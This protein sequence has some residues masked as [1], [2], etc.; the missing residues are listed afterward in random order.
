MRFSHGLL[1]G[2]GPVIIP[3]PEINVEITCPFSQ[4]KILEMQCD[5]LISTFQDPKTIKD[6][7]E[8]IGRISHGSSSHCADALNLGFEKAFDLKKKKQQPPPPPPGVQLKCSYSGCRR[9][10]YTTPAPYSEIGTNVYC[11]NCN[12]YY[13]SYY[14]LCSGCNYQR[15]SSYTSCQS[16]GKNFV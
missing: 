7:K 1:P 12:G 6:V 4:E 15:T 14:M 13:G 16:C 10:W 5:L 9:G 8:N 3:N 11:P 2:K